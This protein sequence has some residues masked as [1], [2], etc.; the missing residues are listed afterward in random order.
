[1]SRDGRYILS[2]EYQS[3]V[4]PTPME[5]DK[6]RIQQQL[7]EYWPDAPPIAEFTELDSGFTLHFEMPKHTLLHETL[8]DL[9]ADKVFKACDGEY[10]SEVEKGTPDEQS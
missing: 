3:Y 7:N 9:K 10:Y 1:M 6:E 4:E 8:T 5:K 2:Y